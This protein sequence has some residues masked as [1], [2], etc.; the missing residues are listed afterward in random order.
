M[1]RLINEMLET[2]NDLDLGTVTIKEIELL[3]LK[4][5]KQLSPNQIK[6]MRI[7]EK[8]SQAVLAK[9]LNITP[10]TYQKWE[11]GEVVPKGANLKLLRLVYDHGIDYVLH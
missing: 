5:L 6:K 3:N 4:E 9:I 7:R 11:R 10:S 2:A 8:L 1:S